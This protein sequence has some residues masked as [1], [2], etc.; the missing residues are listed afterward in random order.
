MQHHICISYS[1]IL[2]F[3]RGR[4]KEVISQSL[5]PTVLE[6]E[7]LY[8]QL[9]S[10]IEG[11]SH[12][13]RVDALWPHACVF[14][15]PSHVHCVRGSSGVSLFFETLTAVVVFTQTLASDSFKGFRMKV[16]ITQMIEHASKVSNLYPAK[17]TPWM[18]HLPLSSE[19]QGHFP[20]FSE[21]WLVN[22]MVGRKKR[23]AAPSS[24]RSRFMRSSQ[25]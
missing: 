7:F 18:Q 10:P 5:G 13:P 23:N 19:F 17:Y 9:G 22:Q 11:R 20:G 3:V 12:T 6:L 8:R 21:A 15:I 25:P 14:C 24:E 4:W 1:N 16:H 2:S